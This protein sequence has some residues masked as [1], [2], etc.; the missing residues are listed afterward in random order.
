MCS[1]I[2]RTL[3]DSEKQGT[4]V[5]PDNQGCLGGSIAEIALV[6]CFAQGTLAGCGTL[7]VLAYSAGQTTLG[8]PFAQGDFEG[9]TTQDTL[10]G[11]G[12]P[13]M[14]GCSGMQVTWRDFGS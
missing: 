10:G 13:G 11:F 14:L 7:S 1:G 3:G 6:C 4:V 5:V 2:H 8:V 9:F 12:M